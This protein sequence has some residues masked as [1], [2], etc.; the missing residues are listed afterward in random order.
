MGSHGLLSEDD[1][2]DVRLI[3]KNCAIVVFWKNGLSEWFLDAIGSGDG[4]RELAAE[5]LMVAG[6]DYVTFV[7][8]LEADDNG[9]AYAKLRTQEPSQPPVVE[10]FKE[11]RSPTV[12]DRPGYGAGSCVSPAVEANQA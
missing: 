4:L 9:G 6:Y 7:L 5:G 10:N 1:V 2:F 12:V 3:D 11:M 8:Y